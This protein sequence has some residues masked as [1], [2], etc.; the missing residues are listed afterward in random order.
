MLDFMTI[1]KIAAVKNKAKMANVHVSWQLC[2]GGGDGV[3]GDRIGEEIGGGV[4]N[5]EDKVREYKLG[6]EIGGVVVN[7]G[8]KVRE[9][10]LGKKMVAL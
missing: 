8:E 9:Y 10:G 5:G 7:G 3:R 2:S 6:E 4:V 1:A